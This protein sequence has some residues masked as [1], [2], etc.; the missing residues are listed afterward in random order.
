MIV[1]ERFRE[2]ATA[3]SEVVS[4]TQR[5]KTPWDSNI[6]KNNIQ[7]RPHQ[8]DHVAKHFPEEDAHSFLDES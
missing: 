6:S 3:C 5:N 1:A 8:R 4:I 7:R 2:N